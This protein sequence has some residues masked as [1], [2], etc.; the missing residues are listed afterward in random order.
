MP[1][2]REPRPG[3]S[4][5]SRGE[6]SECGFKPSTER[7]AVGE[8]SSSARG[9]RSPKITLRGRRY[10]QLLGP[11]DHWAGSRFGALPARR[12]IVG[13]QAGGIGCAPLADSPSTHII[14]VVDV[15]LKW[16]STFATVLAAPKLRASAPT[17]LSSKL[18][19]AF[20]R[21]FMWRLSSFLNRAFHYSCLLVLNNNV[22]TWHP[23]SPHIPHQLHSKHCTS[24][25]N[26]MIKDTK[27]HLCRPCCSSLWKGPYC[28]NPRHTGKGRACLLKRAPTQDLR[29]WDPLP[30]S[31]NNCL[32]NVEESCNP[33]LTSSYL[34]TIE[35][36]YHIEAVYGYIE[37]W[38]ADVC[39]VECIINP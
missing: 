10:K 23:L 38:V 34:Q 11:S 4:A 25:F 26:I 14:F 6:G 21:P 36:Y 8:R 33:S 37:V 2:L 29:Q 5:K 32:Q 20:L 31:A 17:N 24:V 3:G 1:G 18:Q 19:A 39:Y 16:D 35:P 15:R 30:A 28:I 12:H 22:C 7:R 9:R 27:I 13:L